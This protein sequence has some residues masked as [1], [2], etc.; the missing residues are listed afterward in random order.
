MDSL[1]GD[2]FPARLFDG[3]SA[4]PTRGRA[5]VDG[6]WLRFAPDSGRELEWPIADIRGVERVADEAHV[7]LPPPEEGAPEPRL[8][9]AGAAFVEHVDAAGARFGGTTAAAARR[10][11]RRLGLRG[12][13]TIALVVVPLG[14]LVYTT[15]LPRLHVLVPPEREAALGEAVFESVRSE[16]TPTEDAEFERVVA[17]MVAELRDPASPFEL[18]VTLVDDELTNAMAL[19]GGRVLVFRGLILEAPSAD[20]FAGVLAHEIA[21]VE[22]RHGLQ[23]VLRSV[24]LLTFAGAAVGGSL[25]GFELAETIVEASSGLLILKHSRAHERDADE[26]A[27]AKLRRA[28]RDAG[29]LAEF[30]DHLERAEGDL[31]GGLGWLSTHP[32][33]RERVARVRRLALDQGATRP[34]MSA[35]AW[36]AFQARFE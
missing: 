26:V 11:R 32:M 35:E 21:H 19:P 28:G 13:I 2:D 6:A 1:E 9:V 34:W 31:P 17:A 30:F 29:G 18:R 4:V 20:A 24:G 10:V 15:L 3:R 5:R 25:D 12:W 8:V 16:W 22:R 23:H 33:H 14:W 36:R 27:V 7:E